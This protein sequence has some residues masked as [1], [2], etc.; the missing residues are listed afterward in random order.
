ME[1]ETGGNDDEPK[2]LVCYHPKETVRGTKLGVG[3]LKLQQGC[4]YSVQD[5]PNKDNE[6]VDH[7]VI[8]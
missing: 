8:T 1:K 2:E 5:I 6:A 3:Y 7:R 4:D